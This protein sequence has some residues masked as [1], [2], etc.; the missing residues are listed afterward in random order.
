MTTIQNNPVNYNRN[1]NNISPQERLFK[2]TAGL[3]AGAA[4]GY[5]L[6]QTGNILL[7]PCYKNFMSMMGKIHSE[8]SDVIFKEADRMLKESGIEQKGF[9]GI[10]IG[11]SVE[12]YKKDLQSTY[13]KASTYKKI[14]MYS[15]EKLGILANIPYA[16]IG[17][18][19]KNL[20][21]HMAT[22]L[23]LGVY[24]PMNNSIY[25]EFG[26]SLLH[27][28]GHAINS[29]KN[30]FTKIPRKAA[31]ASSVLLIPLAILTA[32]FHK[33]RN[34]N[35]NNSQNS[36]KS[37]LE[38]IKDFT[39]NHIGLTVAVLSLP[40]LAEE[41]MA[42]LRAVNFAKKSELLTETAKKTHSK[43][44]GIA[45]GTYIAQVALLST[46][47]KTSVWIK[48]KIAGNK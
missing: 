48:N 31:L 9:Q 27:E 29:N 45:F 20:E 3:T 2:Q 8:N 26:S 43:I 36:N 6:A 40:L 46:M 28:S 37:R 15:V 13:K 17:K 25:S 4:A 42:T 38:K 16:L 33:K 22:M 10:K 18:I 32:M 35:L 21:N 23:R 19:D 30:F 11:K 14:K 12:T 47:A 41:G 34:D 1:N 7:K 39:K 44:L 24:C 5:V